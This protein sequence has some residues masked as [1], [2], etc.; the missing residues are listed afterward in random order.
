M[1]LLIRAFPN[2]V[3]TYV[4]TIVG[5]NDEP[6]IDLGRLQ[7]MAKCDVGGTSSK[8]MEHWWQQHLQ[9]KV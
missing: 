2:T 6:H 8:N 5:Y 3:W 9:D 4:E 7:M 1:Q